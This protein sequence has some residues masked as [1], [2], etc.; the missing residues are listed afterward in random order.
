MFTAPPREKEWISWLYLGIWS[1]FIYTTVPL[2]R[3]I[4]LF[5]SDQWGRQTFEYVVL[6]VIIIALGISVRYLK[7]QPLKTPWRYAW[8]FGV[9]AVFVGYTIHLRALPEEA[10]HF[11]EYGVLGLLAYRALTHRIRDVGIFISAALIGAIIGTLDEAFQWITPRRYWG[12]HDIWLNFFA[13]ALVQ[14]GIA[15]GIRPP[16]ISRKPRG[17][18]VRWINTESMKRG[19]IALCPLPTSIV[20]SSKTLLLRSTAED[21]PWESKAFSLASSN[22]KRA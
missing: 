22:E 5:V 9:S 17:I 21:C 1:I 15:M 2:A 10:L 20:R 4:Q 19:W 18:S 14:V 11:V 7:R 13:A 8:L 6:A 16:L 3:S 12:L